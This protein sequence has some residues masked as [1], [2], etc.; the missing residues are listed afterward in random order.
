MDHIHLKDHIVIHKIGKRI[1]VCDNTANL[2]CCQ[3]YIL[4]LFLCKKCFY[5]ILSA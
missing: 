5:C 1:L 3:K 2:S 4:W